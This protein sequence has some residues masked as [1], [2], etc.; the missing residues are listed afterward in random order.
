M[1]YQGSW[2]GMRK[3]LEQDILAECLRGRIR[4]NCPGGVNLYEF[5][6]IEVC[7]DGKPYKNFSWE[8]VNSYFIRQGYVQKTYPMNVMDYWKDYWNTFDE[9]PMA[10]RAEYT[11]REFAEA[12]GAY[13]QQDI[14]SSLASENPIVRMFAVLDRRVGKRTLA[15]LKEETKKQPEWLRILMNYG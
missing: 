8:A 3:F 14:Q 11:D 4:Y 5:H 15:T 9:Y 2:S 10:S 12:L 1:G 13:R 6:R 7:V